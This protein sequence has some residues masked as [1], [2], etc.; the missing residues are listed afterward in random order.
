MA[1]VVSIMLLVGMTLELMYVIETNFRQS[2]LAMYVQVIAF[3]LWVKR[4]ILLLM[5]DY[6]KWVIKVGVAYV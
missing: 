4:S 2:Q 3:T 5:Y 6:F 1:A